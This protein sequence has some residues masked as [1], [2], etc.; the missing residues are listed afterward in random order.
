MRVVPGF[1]CYRAYV[2]VTEQLS[3]VSFLPSPEGLSSGH[4]ADTPDLC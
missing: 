1:V 2:E 4:Q 3:G